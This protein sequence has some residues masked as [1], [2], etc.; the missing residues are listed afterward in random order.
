MREFLLISASATERVVPGREMLLI[1]V[2]AARSSSPGPRTRSSGRSHPGVCRACL[3]DVRGGY[4]F[5]PARTDPWI[6]SVAVLPARGTERHGGDE[7]HAS[8]ETSSVISAGVPTLPTSGTP[9]ATNR[10]RP[11]APTR[12]AYDLANIPFSGCPHHIPHSY[13]G[14]R[15]HPDQCPRVAVEPDSKRSRCRTGRQCAVLPVRDRLSG[16]SIEPIRARH[17]NRR[18]RTFPK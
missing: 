14:R 9:L 2:T 8:G 4:S 1:T 12:Y 13:T 10:R 17:L 6:V 5:Q 18:R 3:E 7:D 15:E 16:N 11:P